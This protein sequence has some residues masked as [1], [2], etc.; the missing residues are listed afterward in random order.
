MRSAGSLGIEAAQDVGAEELEAAVDV[1]YPDAEE[2]LGDR[3]EGRAEQ[4]ALNRI[5]ALDAESGD[6]VV[7][8]GEWRE[9]GDLVDVELAVGVHERDPVAARRVEA[10][11]ESRAIAPILRVMDD[12]HPHIQGTCRYG[13]DSCCPANRRRECSGIAPSQIVPSH[14]SLCLCVS[15]FIPFPRVCGWAW[16]AVRYSARAGN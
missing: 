12:S 6:D 16:C 13:G 4:H 2:E 14:S 11:A 9:L 8:A 1:A 5:V 7:A 3:V 10:A 15:C